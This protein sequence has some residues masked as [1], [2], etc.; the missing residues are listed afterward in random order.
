MRAA[1]QR[2]MQH[3][4]VRASWS[5]PRPRTSYR[6]RPV[7]PAHPAVRRTPPAPHSYARSRLPGHRRR[8]T[9]AP[10]PRALCRRARASYS[11]ITAPRQP[12]V[13]DWHESYAGLPRPE[14]ICSWLPERRP[15]P[16]FSGPMDGTPTRRVKCGAKSGLFPQGS[17]T[18]ANWQR[19]STRKFPSFSYRQYSRPRAI[20]E[21]RYRGGGDSPGLPGAS[22][23]TARALLSH[24]AE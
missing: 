5:R 12:I 20:P 9:K 22:R 13:F 10:R 8:P 19:L 17:I 14:G 6:V 2:A 18:D 15:T 11:G 7:S 3:A 4:G 21:V 23:K 24:W 16:G 1:M